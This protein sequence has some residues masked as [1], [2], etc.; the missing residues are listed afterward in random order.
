MTSNYTFYHKSGNTITIP[1]NEVSWGSNLEW[2]VED[3]NLEIKN[4]VGEMPKGVWCWVKSYQFKMGGSGW[5]LLQNDY[6]T[7]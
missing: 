6:I 3:V 2:S 7:L 4:S 5:K 1:K